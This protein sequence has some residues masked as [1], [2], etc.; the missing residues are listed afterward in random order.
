ME[1][2]LV[3]TIRLAVFVLCVVSAR[4]L[5][6][7][8]GIA[9]FRGATTVASGQSI[10]SHSRVSFSGA[11]ARVDVDVD[12]SAIAGGSG[13]ESPGA[14][15]MTIIQKAS[16]PDRMYM[17]NEA[18]KT[19]SVTHL[20]KAS[21]NSSAETFTV[22]KTGS[23]KVAGLPCEKAMVTSS[24]GSESELCVTKQLVASTAWLNAM[25]RRTGGS[26]MWKALRDNGLEGFP[27]RIVTHHGGGSTSQIE[28]V[29]FQKTSVPSSTFQI[30][31]GYKESASPAQGGAGAD[32]RR[33]AFASMTPEQRK[34]M[35]DILRQ[36]LDKAPPE[37]RK[38][39]EAQIKELEGNP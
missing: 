32:A 24:S 10:P 20:D 4:A 16:E 28:L 31:A 23:D 15:K 2:G 35:A 36:N 19:Y 9:E 14:Y 3:K 33:K 21:D 6:Q 38:A 27:I 18:Q 13:G 22:K 5:A 17:L 34:Q 1:E 11:S 12:M 8:E 25:N 29:S 30:P 7:S 26:G 37:Q 39:I